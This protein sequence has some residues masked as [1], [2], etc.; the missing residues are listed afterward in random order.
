MQS[1][2]LLEVLKAAKRLAIRLRYHGN[3]KRHTGTN[4]PAKR[5]HVR[6]NRTRR[7]LRISSHSSAYIEGISI[8]CR[9]MPSKSFSFIFRC[10][11]EWAWPDC[12]MASQTFKAVLPV[13]RHQFAFILAPRLSPLNHSFGCVFLYSSSCWISSGV[14]QAK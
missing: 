12:A 6:L 4:R 13:L 5:Q 10:S 9:L 14:R 1:Y 2:L 3:I 8:S 11:M 7:E